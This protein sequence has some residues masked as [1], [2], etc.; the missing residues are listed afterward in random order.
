M[1][2]TVDIDEELLEAAKKVL[3]TSTIVDTV[4]RSLRFVTRQHQLGA[5]ADA[6]G[7]ID[8]DLTPEGL[9]RQRRKRTA[10]A[11]R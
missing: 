6:L 5:L 8:L 1:K 10:R 4:H 11:A 2:T 9:R 7:T 3:K